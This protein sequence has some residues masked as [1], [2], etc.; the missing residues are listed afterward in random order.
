MDRKGYTIK[1]AAEAWGVSVYKMTALSRMTGFPMIRT[2]KRGVLIPAV[3]LDR[4]MAEQATVANGE[5]KRKCA[6]SR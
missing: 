1:G 5:G 6:T 2:G 4:W 3:E